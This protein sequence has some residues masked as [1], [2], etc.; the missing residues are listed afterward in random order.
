MTANQKFKNWMDSIPYG[1]YSDIRQRVIDECKINPP[2]YGN[3]RNGS[4][5]IPPLAQDVIN[6]I[7]GYNIFADASPIN[8]HIIIGQNIT[9]IE[10]GYSWLVF[11]NTSNG[12]QERFISLQN[13]KIKDEDVEWFETFKIVKVIK[14]IN[15][16]DSSSIIFEPCT[17]YNSEIMRNIFSDYLKRRHSL[18]QS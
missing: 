7:A 12:T 8:Q 9:T 16:A 5:T 18:Y 4:C 17:F 3:W 14:Y 2:T 13:I 11:G 10:Q 6:E 1:E 15:Y